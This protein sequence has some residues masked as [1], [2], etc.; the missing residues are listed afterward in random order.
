MRVCLSGAAEGMPQSC[1]QRFAH[2]SAAAVCLALTMW[3]EPDK[4]AAPR[5]LTQQEYALV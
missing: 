5:L 2:L 4:A 1:M 3:E